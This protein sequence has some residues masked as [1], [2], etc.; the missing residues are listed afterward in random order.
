MRKSFLL[1]FFSAIIFILVIF[2]LLIQKIVIGYTLLIL[3]Y[4]L[5]RK[6]D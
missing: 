1:K 4:Y 3:G 6:S 2:S 5:L